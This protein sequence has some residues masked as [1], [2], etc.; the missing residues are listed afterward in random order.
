MA[1]TTD[2]ATSPST[3]HEYHHTWAV[4]VP[5]GEAHARDIARRH[6]FLFHGQIGGLDG[7]YHLELDCTNAS[8]AHCVPRHEHSHHL[9]RRL[10]DEEH[11]G[12][13][14]QQKVL[15]RSRRDSISDYAATIPDPMFEDQWYLYNS[16]RDDHNVIPVWQRGITGKGVVV[17]IVD[18][19]IEYTHADLKANYDP[20]ASHD[21]N[22]RDNDPMP[23]ELDPIN[24]HGTRCSGQVA[25]GKNKVCGT[26]IAYD[27]N[28]GGV[29]MLD[30][31][32]TDAVE[33][34]S[35]GLNP[36]YIHIYSNSWGPNDDGRTLEG[37]GPL[38]RKALENGVQNG[39]QGKGSIFVFASGNGGSS[40][41]CNCDGYTNSMYTISI[42]ALDES[43]S[44]PYYNE[45]CASTHA[46][47][48]SSGSGRSISTVDLHNG[49]TRSHTGTS[50]AAP[51]AAGFIALA[52]SANPDLTWRD[53]QHIIIN[54]ARKVNPYDTTWTENGAGFKHSDKFGF[55]LIDAEKL[56]DAALAWRTVGPQLQLEQSKTAN[57]ALETS[58]YVGTITVEATQTGI[59]TLEHVQVHVLCDAYKRG[60]VTI[61]IESPTGVVSELLPYRS[62]DYEHSGI[63]WTFMTLR[64]WGESPIGTWTL[65][66][67]VKGSST[68]L[69]KTWKLIAYGT[70]SAGEAGCA[71]GTFAD[72]EGICVPCDEQC[73][74]TG[75]TGA[76]PNECN[77]CLHYTLANG[78]CVS[79]CQPYGLLTP[80][81]D[82]GTCLPCHPLCQGG[83]TD[84]TAMGCTSCIGPVLV[85]ETVHRDQCVAACPE[86]YYADAANLCLE[87]NPLCATCHGPASTDCDTCA[88]FATDEGTCVSSCAAGTYADGHACHS[89]H[90]LCATCWGPGEANCNSCV[91]LSEQGQ[92]VEAC[93][94]GFFD[95]NAGQCMPCAANCTL[96][97]GPEAGDCLRCAEWRQGEA[98][99]AACADNYFGASNG[100]CRPCHTE[101]AA[102]CQGPSNLDCLPA[103][104]PDC[105]HVRLGGACVA[106]CPAGLQQ[107]ASGECVEC[108]ELCGAAG[109]SGS[110]L[111]DCLDCA[112]AAYNGTCVASCPATTFADAATSTCQP[113]A[114]A[115]VAGCSGPAETDCDAADCH[116]VT[117]PDGQFLDV[118]QCR[119]TLC[120]EA[121][122]TCSGPAAETCDTCA[123]AEYEGTCVSSCPAGTYLEAQAQLCLACDE[124]CLNGCTGAGPTQC[125]ACLHAR[126]GH[127]CVAACPI[128][129]FLDASSQTCVECDA[130]C[131][132]A[133]SGA[134]PSACTSC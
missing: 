131:L 44:E 18:D 70:G 81:T 30:G 85:N 50:A 77:A 62:H 25:A 117:C 55:G 28:I 32:V 74:E 84:A 67:N 93:S 103:E 130:E 73:A 22:G 100:E 108:H 57:H 13:A 9:T 106:D 52:L 40:D 33:A 88:A 36:G 10:V 76:G 60:T 122:A 97:T 65:R 59:T 68:A 26:G 63:D 75:C 31:A 51:S 116:D 12:W 80:S 113:C 115:C 1:T 94:S 89:C 38:A 123:V 98:C 6:G 121:C 132:D 23:N 90:A 39:R 4:H 56:V 101:C 87:C 35:L 53:M 29:R 128:A 119:C 61:S 14:E 82:T 105:V 125:T 127:T 111:A 27:A 134:G 79:D 7:Y 37:P 24:R 15:R 42:G 83:C 99:V 102:G 104:E 34:G 17:T 11:V 95:N 78:T 133:C 118:S 49:C 3:E 45:R 41:S 66:A 109:C 64:H 71:A 21:M 16:K 47:A 86:G 126:L 120:N 46:V 20:K 48:Y 96:C 5:H 92:C 2:P 69:L 124:Q 72:S 107:L 19:G 54:T 112:V 110:G 8:G 129:T 114:T 58:A 43:N 91:G